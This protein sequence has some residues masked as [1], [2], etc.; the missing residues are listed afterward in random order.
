[1][2]LIRY[3]YELPVELLVVFVL[4]GVIVADAHNEQ[5]F[6]D[7]FHVLK[8]TQPMV[9]AHSVEFRKEDPQN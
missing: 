4:L 2:I 6:V 9:F 7:G 8:K 1:M 5:E 3:P